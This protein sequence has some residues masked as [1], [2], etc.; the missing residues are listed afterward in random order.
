MASTSRMRQSKKTG[1]NRATSCATLACAGSVMCP[2]R[3]NNMK[4]L[5]V[6]VSTTALTACGTVTTLSESDQKISSN[7]SRAESYCE[8]VPRVY[9]GVAYDVCKLNSKPSGTAIDLV[10]G[11]YLM[12]GILS[13][14]TD[15]LV[16]PYTI[17]QQSRKGSIKIAD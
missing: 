3:E 10:V 5:L 9:S 11:F 7:L 1:A 17:V 6:L 8:S 16:L 2:I 12:D 15:T 13:A 4:I 14:A